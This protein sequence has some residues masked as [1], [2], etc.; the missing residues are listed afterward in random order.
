MQ[1]WTVIGRFAQDRYEFDGDTYETMTVRVLLTDGEAEI[2]TAR[3]AFNRNYTAHPEIPLEI[4]LQQEV[5]KAEAAAR[6]VNDML[7]DEDRRRAEA[8]YETR[9]RVR[10]IMGDPTGKPV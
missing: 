3:A 9:A 5:E 6:I 1:L 10:E 4:I 7:D 8:V 2:E